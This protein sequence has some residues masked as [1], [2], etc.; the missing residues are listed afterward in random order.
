MSEAQEV[1]KWSQGI[2]EEEAML[3]VNRSSYTNR[4]ERSLKVSLPAS[5]S[6]TITVNYLKRKL[7]KWTGY[8]SKTISL[9]NNKWFSK[10][11]I[12]KSKP[13]GIGSNSR[14]ARESITC[15]RTCRKAMSMVRMAEVKVWFL[16]ITLNQQEW[17]RNYRTTLSLAQKPS[18]CQVRG[19]MKI[20]IWKRRRT[21]L[22]NRNS[23]PQISTTHLRF[24]TT[25]TQAATCMRL[26][27]I[28]PSVP[29]I[30]LKVE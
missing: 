14:R 26:Q 11:P 5:T 10:I 9:N 22:Q 30:I 3:W 6:M 7:H 12:T 8:S 25:K 23:S 13:T 16:I 24:N 15:L 27:D 17:F 29:S 18:R 1:D 2:I 4:P 19:A 28:T 21:D 20:P